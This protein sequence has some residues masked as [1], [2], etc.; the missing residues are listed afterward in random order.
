[1]IKSKKVNQ[2]IQLDHNKQLQQEEAILVKDNAIVI[3]DLNGNFTYVNP[4]FLSMWGYPNEKNVLGKHATTFWIDEQ[5]ASNVIETLHEQRNWIGE[6]TAK[7]SD[8][9]LFDVQ[10]SA[11]IVEGDT[12]QSKCIIGSFLN[13]TECKQ[14]EVELIK[15]E[16]RFRSLVE[17]TSDWIWEVD[18]EGVYT[19]VSPKV[20][21]MLGYNPEEVLGKTPF[22]LMPP[23]EAVRVSRLFKRIVKSRKPFKE[24]ENTNL[25][26]AG[27]RV[28]LETSGVPI[29]DDSGNL[30]GYRGIDRD[31]TQRRRMEE[32]LLESEERLRSTISSMDDLVFLLDRNGN[33]LDFYQPSKIPDLFIPPKDFLG[34]SFKEVL[35][36]D[37][38]RQLA[39]AIRSAKATKKV[40]Q[41]DYSLE[42][43]GKLLWFN[44]KVSLRKNSAGKFD[45][46]TVVVRNITHRKQ[47]ERDLKKSYEQVHNLSVHL[48]W[49]REEE[50]T[51]I[52]REIHDEL[53]Q[54]LTVLKM[55]LS[56][57]GSKILKAEN[58]KSRI[59]LVKK[60]ESMSNL[61]DKTI[62][63]VQKMVEELKP[64]ILDELGLKEAIE[65]YSREFQ[66]RTGIKCD[67]ISKIEELKLES[68]YSCAIFRIFQESLTNVARHAQADCVK[69]CLKE[70][71]KNLQLTLKDN[72]KGI[73]EKEIS[74]TKSIG[75]IGMRERALFLGGN[76]Q[77]LGK[78]GKGTTVILNI[79]LSNVE[80][81][82][83][84]SL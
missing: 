9:S 35:P 57:I 17:T 28:V 33:F 4:S 6:L 65:W 13:V 79:P 10:L 25:H 47:L 73:T 70:E 14:Y 63:T 44:A 21:E 20:K 11:T 3:A 81:D 39:T 5:K 53:G 54:V 50:R 15:N 51:S 18:K 30:L 16:G 7:R 46:V 40:Q 72:G 55:E 74:D 8:G 42:I 75:L 80:M 31:I 52:A 84:K 41:F 71:S 29:L 78:P 27:R 1:M 61:T 32:N 38:A 59:E 83:H 77:F 43:S 66:F 76:I 68:D 58:M 12:G 26:K 62:R 22:D 36:S 19:Y 24:L 56:F 34:K 82:M 49:A 67:I 64:V 23:D 2:K 69:I 37:V 45:G 60:I 48:Q